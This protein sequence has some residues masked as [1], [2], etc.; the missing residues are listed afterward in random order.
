MIEPGRVVDGA[1]GSPVPA[2]AESG[3]GVKV[4]RYSFWNAGAAGTIRFTEHSPPHEHEPAAAACDCTSDTEVRPQGEP[5]QVSQQVVVTRTFG[6]VRMEFN[7]ADL[8]CKFFWDRHPGDRV[9]SRPE[10]VDECNHAYFIF[11]P[12][13]R[14]L[15]VEAQIPGYGFTDHMLC[16]VYFGNE[17]DIGSLM[18]GHSP[19]RIVRLDELAPGDVW[20]HDCGFGVE[21]MERLD[22]GNWET[23]TWRLS[24]QAAG[25]IERR[26]AE[27]Y[28]P[29]Q[30]T[31]DELRRRVEGDR[32]LL[33]TAGDLGMWLA[34]TLRKI[35]TTEIFRACDVAYRG[36]HASS[37]AAKSASSR[38]G[39]RA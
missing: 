16:S 31:P 17:V 35:K 23:A 24:M 25:V 1:A 9:V 4:T 22:M 6:D 32:T 10:W 13:K 36:A 15:R 39:E 28:G 14:A 18:N 30:G 20:A 27:S 29:E 3:L 11:S 19:S 8:W 34:D 5:A 2:L 7:L 37:L 33:L 12:A 38:D 26:M 21:A